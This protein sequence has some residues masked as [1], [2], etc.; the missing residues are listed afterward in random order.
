MWELLFFMQDIKLAMH[1][2]HVSLGI[3]VD[4][5]GLRMHK[6]ILPYW[7]TW[8][9]IEHFGE[10]HVC[11]IQNSVK[12]GFPERLCFSCHSINSWHR[13]LLELMVSQLV[14][15]FCA[16]YGTLLCVQCTSTG[17][18]SKSCNPGVMLTPN[19]FQFHFTV[20]PSALLSFS[21]TLLSR[22]QS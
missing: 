12:Q 10:L 22:F 14:N 15:K 20:V 3:T 4:N 18:L 6:V 5:F 16:W 13:G 2:R 7:Q 9:V 11:E 8:I 19:I 21:W 1:K 17:P